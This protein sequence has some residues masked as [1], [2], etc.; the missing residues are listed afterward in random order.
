MKIDK[1]DKIIVIPLLTPDVV[2]CETL[3]NI[4]EI[5]LVYKERGSFRDKNPVMKQNLGL[6]QPQ[7]VLNCIVLMDGPDSG[8]FKKIFVPHNTTMDCTCTLGQSS[9]CVFRSA[10]TGLGIRVFGFIMRLCQGSVQ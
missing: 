9:T 10:G 1:Q 7:I 3:E 2:R 6:T 4:R 5:L 8:G